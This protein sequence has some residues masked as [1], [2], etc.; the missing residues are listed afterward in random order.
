MD[1][2]GTMF[3]HAATLRVIPLRIRSVG[4]M[5]RRNVLL[6]ARFADMRIDIRTHD[7]TYRVIY[8]KQ[9]VITGGRL[10]I[11]AFV[12]MLMCIKLIDFI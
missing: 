6:D 1:S 7:L 10:F 4:R 3:G 2:P 5:L 11:Y 12:E 8:A 9:L